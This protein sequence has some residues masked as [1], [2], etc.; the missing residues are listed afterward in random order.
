MLNENCSFCPAVL[1]SV[2]NVRDHYKDV[3]NITDSNPVFDRY[4]GN[5]SS[6]SVVLL[7]VNVIS[8]TS[9]STKIEPR[10][11]ILSRSI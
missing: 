7:T 5:L 2:E 8:A 11:N 3:H 6:N 9:F 1:E 4:L 10:Q